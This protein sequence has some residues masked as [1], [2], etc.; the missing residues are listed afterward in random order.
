MPSLSF[1]LGQQ[2]IIELISDTREGALRELVDV[3]AEQ[4]GVMSDELFGEVWERECLH[5]TGFGAGLALPHIRSAHL[6]QFYVALGRS[7][8]G[9]PFEAIDGEPV[10]LVLLVAGPLGERDRYRKLMAR[11]AK[12]LKQEAQAL[13]GCPRLLESVTTALT[14]Y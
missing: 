8:A 10:Q 3:V 13:R 9:L 12:F 14:D 11:A 5:S 2:H 4:A 7:Q 6:K 1:L